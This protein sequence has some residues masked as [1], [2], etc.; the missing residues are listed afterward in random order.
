L[1]KIAVVFLLVFAMAGSS[2]ALNVFDS[3]MGKRV[4]LNAIHRTVL[5]NRV[6]GEVKYFLASDNKKWILLTGPTKSQFQGYYDA[7]V[8]S[9]KH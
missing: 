6:T 4:F 7:Q 9:L 2:Y 1:K 3:M 5:V 8:A